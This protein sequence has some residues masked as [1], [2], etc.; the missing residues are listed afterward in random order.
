MLITG[1]CHT[2]DVMICPNCGYSLNLEERECPQCRAKVVVV[3]KKRTNIH[4]D[5]E[6]NPKKS[7]GC[8]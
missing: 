3:R 6:D 2:T 4:P 1:S 5:R 8:L 7:D